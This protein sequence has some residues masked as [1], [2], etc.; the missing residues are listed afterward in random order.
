MMNS[1]AAASRINVAPSSDEG[2]F[3]K[4]ATQVV[5]LDAVNETFLVKG[6]A[7]L[8]TANHTDLTITEDTLITCQQVVNPFT[9]LYEKVKD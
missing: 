9:G 8:E 7:V 5:D 2:H 1:M 4:G 6:G 3:V